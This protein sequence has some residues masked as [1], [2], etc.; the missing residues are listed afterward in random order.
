MVNGE[1]VSG[2]GVMSGEGVALLRYTQVASY[3]V[4]TS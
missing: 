1:G 2:E 3:S 4:A